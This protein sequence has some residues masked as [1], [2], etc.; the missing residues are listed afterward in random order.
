[1][2][3]LIILG[4][5]RSLIHWICSFLTE[6]CQAVKL[7]SVVSDWKIT[8]ASVPQGTKLGPILFVIMINDLALKSPL[9]S[10]H[11][12]FVDDVTIS[13]T[14][15]TGERSLIQCDLD[16]ISS[17]STENNMN[18]NPKKCKEML[19]WPLKNILDVTPLMETILERVS[20]IQYIKL[21]G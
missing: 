8:H 6:R 16:K 19:L 11:W 20:V 4:V 17:W 18:L 1:M 15:D 13:E 2:R 9:R 5:R 14:I 3:K 21:L 10:N 12:K 7:E